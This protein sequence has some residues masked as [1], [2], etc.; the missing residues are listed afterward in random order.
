MNV[1]KYKYKY[2]I[3]IVLNVY[4]DKK[5]MNIKDIFFLEKNI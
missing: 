3:N 4:F 1:C 2:K 5:L